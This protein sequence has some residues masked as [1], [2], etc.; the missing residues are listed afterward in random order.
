MFGEEYLDDGD[1]QAPPD[2]SLSLRY[3][4]PKSGKSVESLRDMVYYPV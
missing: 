4:L 3:H 1:V 2:T